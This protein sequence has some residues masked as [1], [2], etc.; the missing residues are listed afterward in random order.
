MIINFK[1]KYKSNTM[2]GVI[3]NLVLVSSFTLLLPIWES[4]LYMKHQ[5]RGQQETHYTSLEEVNKKSFMANNLQQYVHTNNVQSYY[6]LQW[7]MI[8]S[9]YKVNTHCSLL[10]TLKIWD[11][12]SYV[13]K[14]RLFFFL[15]YFL[16]R[17]LK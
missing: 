7:K 6:L 10:Y 5:R 1:I 14:K 4:A 8:E 9:T 11:Y 12:L 13:P 3:R 15:S 16:L 2:L 17:S